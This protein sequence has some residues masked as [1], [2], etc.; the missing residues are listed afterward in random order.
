M[1]Y[2]I[3]VRLPIAAAVLLMLCTGGKAQTLT[4]CGRSDGYAYYFSGGLIPAD[5]SGLQKDGVDG[6][7]IILN[8]KNGEVDLLIRDRTGTTRSVRQD[9]GKLYVRKTTYGLIAVSVFYEEGAQATEDYV[10]QIDRSGNGTVVW[11][12]VRTAAD[13]VNKVSI[14]TAACRGP[15]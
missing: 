7:R 8:Y 9:S 6:G 2:V 13:T 12:T 3:P 1:K 5:Q 4:E 14:M 15:R 10:F 11:T